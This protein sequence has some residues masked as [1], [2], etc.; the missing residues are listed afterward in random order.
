MSDSARTYGAERAVST[1]PNGRQGEGPV[2]SRTRGRRVEAVVARLCVMRDP[3]ARVPVG[4]Y[5]RTM[6]VALCLLPDRVREW[7]VRRNY[8]L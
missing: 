7:A 5:A 4:E 2:A 3:P 8:A 6:C 1:I